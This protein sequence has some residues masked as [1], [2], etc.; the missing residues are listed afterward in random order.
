[1]ATT[2]YNDLQKLYVA[3]FNRPADTKGLAYYEGVLEATKGDAK[4]LATT[5]AAISAD[6]STSAEY[7]A[8]YA[9]MSNADIVN[10]I[11]QNIFGRPAED[12]GK[13]YWADLLDSKTITIDNVVT[14]VAAGAQGSDLT[15]FT[16]KVNASLAFTTALGETNSYSGAKANAEAKTFL[17]GVT[18]NASYANATDPVMLAT[19]VA[20]VNLAG[21]PFTLQSALS[22]KAAADTA[23]TNFLDGLDGK[24]DG[25]FNTGTDKVGTDQAARDIA[26]ASVATNVTT[27][28]TALD[29]QISGTSYAS[30][31]AG[32]RAALLADQQAANAAAVTKAQGDLTIANNKLAAVAGLND[33][34]AAQKT[35][36]AN[37]KSTAATAASAATDVQLKLAAY[38]VL[39]KT[40]IANPAAGVYTVDGLIVN[41]KDKGLMLATGVTEDT[42]KGVTAL[43]NSLIAEKAAD[44]AA[45]NAV[46]TAGTAKATVDL[47]DL[48]TAAK[49]DMAE[50]ASKMKLA[51][52]TIATAAQIEAQQKGLDAAAVSAKA[53]SDAYPTAANLKATAD[54][55]TAASDFKALVTKLYADDNADPVNANPLIKAQADATTS[56]TTAQKA[57]TDLSTALSDLAKANMTATQLEAVKTQVTAANGVFDANKLGMPVTL[58]ADHKAEVA[59]AGS[60]IYVAGTTSASIMNFGLLGSDSLYINSK[61]TYSKLITTTD[62]TK[63]DPAALEAFLTTNADGNAVITLEQKAY[64][65]NSGTDLVTITLTGVTDVTKVHLNNGIITVS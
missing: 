17:S 32:V 20:K 65:S 24:V 36:D 42:N 56:L 43:L 10:A 49:A 48:S 28:M 1:M 51:E 35:A 59:S 13:K 30:A 64:G 31:S 58:D 40:A 61:N 38:N 63:G 34:I 53:V 15:A 33:A 21:T 41:D 6:F 11:Y 29:D 60:D 46:T 26:E 12:A 44:T 25:K 23:Y 62:I 47:L 18:D 57:V 55:Q 27:K 5:M 2:Y 7:K 52:G 16:N 3:Y 8:A 9:N 45:K 22:N 37:V 19:T 50:I 14:Q 39:N 4:A 54:A